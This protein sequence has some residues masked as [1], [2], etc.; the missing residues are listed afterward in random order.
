MTSKY[1]III[2]NNKRPRLL[3]IQSQAISI[4]LSLRGILIGLKALLFVFNVFGGKGAGNNCGVLGRKTAT[5]RGCGKSL[6]LRRR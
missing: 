3:V 4:L 2:K 6:G 5:T 1:I